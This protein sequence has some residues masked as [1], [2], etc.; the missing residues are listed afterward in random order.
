M[1]KT[2]TANTDR[3]LVNNSY[4]DDLSD[5]WYHAHDDPIALLRAETRQKLRWCIPLLEQQKAEK[6]A[7]LRAEALKKE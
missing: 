7:K 5:K 4:Y 2:I 3:E 6:I 1:T